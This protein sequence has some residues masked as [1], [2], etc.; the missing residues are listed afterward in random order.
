MSLSP[1]YQFPPYRLLP[2][3]RQLFSGDV[4]VKLGGRAFDMLVALVE[5]RQRTVGKPELMDLVW[6]RL[7]VEENNLQVQ[8]VALRKLLGHAA[9]AT[10][11]GRGYRFTLPVVAEGEAAS[12]DATAPRGLLSAALPALFGRDDDLRTLGRMLEPPGL[13]TVAGPA[14][15]GKTRLAQAAARASSRPGG[16]WWV[17]LASLADPALVPQAVAQA[18]GART[19]GAPDF[20]AAVL[21]VLPQQPA[22]LVLDNA[23]HLLGSVADLVARL[24]AAAPQL[25][26]LVTSQEILHLADEQVFRPEPL[27]LPDGDDPERLAASGAVALFVA[28]AQAADRRFE[29]SADNRATVADIC[30]RLDGIPL[31]IELAAARVPLLGVA[32]LRDK[33]DQRFH[34]LTSGDRSALRRHQTLRAALEWSHQLLAA[35]EQAVLRRLG[36]FAGG[37]TLEAAQQVAEDGQGID[38]WDALDLL[39]ML[40]DKSLVVMEDDAPPRYRLLETTRLFALERLIESGEAADAR[41]RHREHF[42][43]LAEEARG[44]MLVAD[45]RGLARLDRERDNLFLALAWRQA[46]DDGSC[47]LRLAA[48]LRYWWTSRGM[49]VRGAEVLRTA[50][51]HPGAAGPSLPRCMALATLAHFSSLMGDLPEAAARIAEAVHMA[52]GLADASTLCLA[53]GGSGFIALRRGELD[54]AERASAEALALAR[55]L[56]DGHELGNALSLRAAVH[57]ERGE[58]AAARQMLEETV[59]LRR[60]L[61]QL[62]SQAVGHL[63]LAQMA[64]NEGEVPAALAHLREVAALLPR[65]DSEHIGVHL[66]ATAAEWAAVAGR[67]E[68]AVLLDAAGAAQVARVG[69]QLQPDPAQQQRL[70]QARAALDAATC[71]RLQAAGRGLGY[72]AALQQVRDVLAADQAADFSLSKA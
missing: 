66:I 40:V 35:P 3:Q 27:A 37:F 63:N 32:G 54:A 49:L 21:K 56:G 53:L 34:V 64:M 13:V 4:P 52:R 26:L 9:I 18:L 48:A 39:G 62:W 69:L 42:T 8:V 65:I 7:V 2:A 41:T 10:V 51:A 70:A 47:G 19:D 45:P 11:P 38:R 43:L 36:V 14:G 57:G 25:T 1:V 5:R 59:A 71:E 28:R 16:A 67:H 17:D 23:E 6:P 55:G 44:L 60:R 50:L 68:D 12:G 58:T 46:D 29:L 20:M 24:R 33:L 22:L 72:R 61:G 15:I 31:A 30:R